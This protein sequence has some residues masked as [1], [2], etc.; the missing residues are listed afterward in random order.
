MICPPF[1]SKPAKCVETSR[2][3]VSGWYPINR[4]IRIEIIVALVIVC[5]GPFITT[6]LPAVQADSQEY[7]NETVWKD[8]YDSYYIYQRGEEIFKI[9][10]KVKEGDDVDIYLMVPYE[11]ESYKKGENFSTLFM[12]ENVRKVSNWVEN[13]LDGHEDS[14]CYLVIDNKDNAREN[15]AVPSDSVTYE[16]EYMNVDE[17][18]ITDQEIILICGFMAGFLILDIYLAV[19]TYRDSK[20]RDTNGTLWSILVFIFSIL[21]FLVYIV[22]RPAKMMAPAM[23]GEGN[24]GAGYQNI[25]QGPPAYAHGMFYPPQDR[26]MVPQQYPYS[27]PFNDPG[28][29]PHPSHQ[30]PAHPP[31]QPIYSQHQPNME[32]PDSQNHQHL[33]NY[34]DQA[35][36][37]MGSS[38]HV[39]VPNHAHGPKDRYQDHILES[40]ENDAGDHEK[41]VKMDEKTGRIEENEIQDQEEKEMSEQNQKYGK[42]PGKNTS[43]GDRLDLPDMDNASLA[44]RAGDRKRI[45]DGEEEM[46]NF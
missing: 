45:H 21:G 28:V 27:G 46:R 8:S 17:N 10:F 13:D 42:T 41:M 7:D 30:N 18:E 33:Q 26:S 35:Y 25:A 16:L 22:V 44:S 38:P 9:H 6:V 3:D 19:W 32:F 29:P 31:N 40:N 14:P 1:Q 12:K 2:K 20:S 37:Q 15:D 43:L 11:F 4:S 23:Q 36:P 5:G 34:P 39:N 24:P